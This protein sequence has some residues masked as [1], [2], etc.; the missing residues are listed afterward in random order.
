VT[1]G[2]LLAQL[3]T[4]DAP[5]P[6]AVRRY[7]KEFLS[8]RRVVDISPWIWK[9]ILYGFIL[10]TRPKRSAALYERVWTEKGSPLL[11]H[12][13]AQAEGV[14]ERLG[15]R[16]KVLFGMRIGKPSLASQL[17]ELAR[18]KCRRILVLPLFP[19]YSTATSASVEDGIGSWQAAHPNAPPVKVLGSFPTHPAYIAALAHSVREKGVT[20]SAAAP[21]VVSFHGIPQ[22]FA[23]RGDP[24]P[25]EC[26]ATAQALV[27]ALDLPGDAWRLTYQSRFGREAWLQP[28]TE[29]TLGEMARSGIKEMSIVTPSFVADCL[30]TIDEVGRELREVFE[31]AG[32]GR[33]TRVDCVNGS[34]PFLD[35]LVEIVKEAVGADSSRADSS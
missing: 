25:Q 28:Y 29:L 10:R 15:P 2:I 5:T 31:E 9:P 3:G 32:G 7:L 22:R 13:Q 17:D 8:D 20:P 21:L 23:D 16:Y 12:T 24:Y 35:A 33:F 27:K 34:A 4:P 26:G 30:E 11:L 14:A 1:T 6:K 19:Q 18:A